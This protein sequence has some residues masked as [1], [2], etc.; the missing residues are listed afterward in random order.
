MKQSEF[1]IIAAALIFTILCGKNP[2]SNNENIDHPMLIKTN[3]LDT[4]FISDSLWLN[5]DT[6]V[7]IYDTSGFSTASLIISGN[8]NA[9]SVLI[10][11]HGDGLIGKYPLDLNINNQFNDTVAI[12]F[13][14]M[15]GIFI[16]CSTKIFL[17]NNNN[18]TVQITVL[19]PN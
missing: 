10:E 2:I 16:S 8:T 13:S 18:D 9:K 1:Y 15:S 7:W 4:N 17:I 6:L 3:A 14:H 19:N 5:T 11:T 12:G